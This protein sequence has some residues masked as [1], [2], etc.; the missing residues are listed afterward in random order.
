MAA[1]PLPGAPLV[2]LLPIASVRACVLLIVNLTATR[3]R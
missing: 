2:P 1:W 3:Y